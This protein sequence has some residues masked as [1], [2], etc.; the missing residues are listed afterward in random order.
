MIEYNYFLIQYQAWIKLITQ[1]EWI[2]EEFMGYNVTMVKNEVIG[3]KPSAQI[4]FFMPVRY[5][6]QVV[7]LIIFRGSF[8]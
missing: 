4:W 1:K 2:V 7:F 5:I 6:I 3:L 8:V